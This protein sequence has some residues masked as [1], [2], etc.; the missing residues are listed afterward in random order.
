[1]SPTTNIELIESY[2]EDRLSESEKADFEKRLGSDPEFEKE[3][4]DFK[5]LIQG[6]D[7]FGAD[8]FSSTVAGW[9]GEIKAKSQ[10]QNRTQRYRLYAA[11]AIILMVLL[12]IG[13]LLLNPFSG[14]SNDALFAAYFEP[15]DDVITSRAGV[16]DDAL[17]QGMKL[18]EAGSFKESMRFL[19]N[20]VKD[21]PND[22]EAR[23]YLAI[24]ALAS[25]ELD[26]AQ[27]EL[28]ELLQ[29]KEYLFYEQVQWYL[30]LT[31]LK[32]DNHDQLTRVLTT[33]LANDSHSYFSKSTELLKKLR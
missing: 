3:Y 16:A 25:G 11:A 30:A 24:T 12:P 33:I 8:E 29:N 19:K 17:I 32:A 14:N 28:T 22:D 7:V 6:I 2:L 10:T 20:Y 23:F 18:Y 21:Q 5:K 27:K 13:Y 1:M 31:Y 15:Y 4:N 26:I 9:E